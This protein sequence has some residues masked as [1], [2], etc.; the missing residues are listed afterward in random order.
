MAR[1]SPPPVRSIPYALT[2]ASPVPRPASEQSDHATAS[3]PRALSL[4]F[5]SHAP[6]SALSSGISVGVR[7]RSR[8]SVASTAAAARQSC[9]DGGS[10]SGSAIGARGRTRC[11]IGRRTTIVSVSIKVS[12]NTVRA[13][14]RSCEIPTS[15]AVTSTE[16]DWP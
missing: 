15:S 16:M 5:A 11:E 9:V 2:A 4:V 14:M 1:R 6:L 3:P 8:S 7:V 10:S 13:R 12:S